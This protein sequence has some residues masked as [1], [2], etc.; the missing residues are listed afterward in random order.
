MSVGPERTTEP[1]PAPLRLKVL[2]GNAAGTEIRVD[3]EF[4]I[5][6]HAE[7]DGKLEGDVEISREHARISRADSGYVIEDLGSTNGTFVNGRRIADREILSVGDKVAVGGTTLVVQVSVP[8]TAPETA[9]PE[10]APAASV[11]PLTLRIEYGPERGTARLH[12][13]EGSEPL[14]LVHDAHGWHVRGG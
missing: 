13:G 3:D 5:G 9:A 12:L 4:V 2:E 10:P 8:S 11:P 6:R 14:E 7:G 1:N